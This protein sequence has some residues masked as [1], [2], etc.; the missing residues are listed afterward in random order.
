MSLGLDF[1]IFRRFVNQ[2]SVFYFESFVDLLQK[3]LMMIQQYPPKTYD[4]NPFYL[5]WH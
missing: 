2:V 1:D 3:V 5:Y 4:R